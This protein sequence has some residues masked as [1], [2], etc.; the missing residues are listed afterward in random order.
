MSDWPAI[1]EPGL[2]ERM[3]LSL[4][5]F[6]QWV[7]GM[8]E[9]LPAR[10]YGPDALAFAVGYPW[11]RPERSYLITGSRVEL[12]HDLPDE[13]RA[14]VLA[15]CVTHGDAS[16]RIPLLAFGSNAAPSAL[17]RKFAH[18]SD[19][20]DRTVVVI[21]GHLHEFDVGVA[22][23]PTIYGSLPATLFS[24]PG[25]AVRA[26]VL[27]VTSAQFTQL[28]WSEISYHLGRL[29]TRFEADEPEHSVD[30]VLAFASRFD[31]FSPEGR[32]VALAAIPATGRTAPAM[33]QEE[34]LDAA[35]ALALGPEATA[36][37]LVRAVHEDMAGVAPRLAAA[38]HPA[39][40]PFRS[41]RWS[42]FR[43]PAAPGG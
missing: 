6:K 31:V 13:A 27:W 40:T 22:A 2:L 23:Q 9:Q 14:A 36:A 3:A 33:T 15:R 41:E 25:T 32:P 42:R 29:E 5:E 35:A 12:L 11:S 20:N 28:A 30:G 7:V 39:A 24:S 43:V 26:A 17:E 10:P 38:V 1:T 34:L 21:A 8:T 18:F 4:E 16:D 19:E 37:D